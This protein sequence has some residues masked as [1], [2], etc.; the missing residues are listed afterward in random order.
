MYYPFLQE[1]STF[2]DFVTAQAD[3]AVLS[4]W[5]VM[6]SL[7]MHGGFER[8][9]VSFE[10]AGILQLDGMSPRGRVFLGLVV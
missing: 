9:R 2:G 6:E 10:L 5:V 4:V 3:R 7:G 1:F 8:E